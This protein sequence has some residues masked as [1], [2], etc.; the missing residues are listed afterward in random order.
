[1]AGWEQGVEIFAGEGWQP[2][3]GFR[4]CQGWMPN[5][6]QVSMKLAGIARALPPGLIWRTMVVGRRCARLHEPTVYRGLF[7]SWRRELARRGKP[8][9]LHPQLVSVQILPC[10]RAAPLGMWCVC[11]A[12]IAC[13]RRWAGRGREGPFGSLPRSGHAG[14][15]HSALALVVS[16]ESVH[17]GGCKE[18]RNRVCYSVVDLRVAGGPFPDHSGNSL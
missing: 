8:I 9:A 4:Y 1:M 16:P 3:E 7:F 10:R 2:V 17:L 11:A 13:S 18:I 5:F 6:L 15:P 12:A 14:L